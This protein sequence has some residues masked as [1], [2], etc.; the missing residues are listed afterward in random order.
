MTWYTCGFR[1]D[2]E[3]HN[4]NHKGAQAEL[5]QQVG[6]LFLHFLRNVDF[7]NLLNSW[8]LYL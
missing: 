6:V 2:W 8:S 4:N 7:T 1:R 5:P 3:G